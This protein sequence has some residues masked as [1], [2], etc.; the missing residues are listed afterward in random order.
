[1]KSDGN[2]PVIL[3][4][5]SLT[6][7]LFLIGFCGWIALTSKELIKF[8]KQNV[9][10]QVVVDKGLNTDQLAQ[11]KNQLAALNISEENQGK[12]AISMVSKETAAENFFKQTGEN[13]KELLT[14]NPFHDAFTLRLKD[15]FIGEKELQKIKSQIAKIS[16][17]YEVDYPKDMLKGVIDNIY[18]TYKFLAAFV[19]IFFVSTVLLINNTIKLAMYSQR[20]LIRTM[21]LVGATDFFIQKPYLTKGILQGLA[22]SLLSILFLFLVQNIANDQIEGLNLLSKPQ[23]NYILFSVLLVLGPLI[24]FLS[25][26]QSILKYNQIDL[27][28]LY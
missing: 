3:I 19:V 25:T 5:I 28:K 20:F 13:F 8:V 23:N 9:E 21:Q 24:G 16:G 27:D 6:V 18:A 22:S 11:I 26:F 7:A 12:P 10:V 2:Y 1:M 17:V 4:T 15:Q 14:E